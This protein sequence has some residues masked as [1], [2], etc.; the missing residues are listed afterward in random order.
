M[1]SVVVIAMNTFREHLRDKVLYSL[2]FF[3][4]FLIGGAILL[5]SLTIGEQSKIV[6][7]IG[8]AGINLCGVLISIFIGIG[9]VS[10]EIEKRTIY[11]ILA[12]PVQRY[13]FLVGRYIGL[14]ITL[15]VNTSVM[16]VGFLGVLLVS[17]ISSDFGLVKA[18]GLIFVELCV[19]VSMGM[20]FSTFTTPTLSAAFTIAIYIVG[21][22]TND[23]KTLAEKMPEGVTPWVLKGAYYLLPNLEHFNIKGDVVYGVP[24][25]MSYFV[26]SMMYGLI[27]AAMMMAAACVIFERRDF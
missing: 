24:I 1:N 7:D 6:K 10:R 4:L 18:V 12:K 8:L 11:T 16:T 19:L 9:L 15:L 21:H 23:I 26:T 2:V 25:E 14:V 27:Y 13:Q 20:L 22:L 3:G 17:G 5:G